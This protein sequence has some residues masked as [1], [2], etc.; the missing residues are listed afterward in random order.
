[1]KTHLTH[2]FFIVTV[3]LLAVLLIFGGHVYVQAGTP[4]E[5]AETNSAYVIRMAQVG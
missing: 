5:G 3:L 4:P 2:L 1:M